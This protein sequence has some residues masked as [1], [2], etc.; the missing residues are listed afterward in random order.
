MLRGY[1]GETSRGIDPF[2]SQREKPNETHLA[3]SIGG[4][5][6]A[7]EFVDFTIPIEIEFNVRA[8]ISK[9]LPETPFAPK[10]DAEVDDYYI[11]L[12]W[13]KTNSSD[14]ETLR[15]EAMLTSFFSDAIG[16]VLTD[17]QID[18]LRNVAMEKLTTQQEDRI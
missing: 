2:R 16:E 9:G 5:M 10:E 11:S 14:K 13:R 4:L 7:Q 1:W 3:F 17:D 12:N 6:P 18:E 8:F 15:I